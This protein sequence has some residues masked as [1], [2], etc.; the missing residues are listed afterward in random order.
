MTSNMTARN[1]ATTTAGGDMAERLPS[2][3][4]NELRIA[5][6]KAEWAEGMLDFYL[7]GMT[8][9]MDEQGLLLQ[10]VSGDTVRFISVVDHIGSLTAAAMVKASFEEAGV[11]VEMDPFT[12]LIPYERLMEQTE[13]LAD[14][15][16]VAGNDPLGMEVA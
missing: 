14:D 12:V 13:S 15:E 11:A 16:F 5:K 10:V 8:H 2:L 3:S 9:E 4:P 1:D 7:P 6:E